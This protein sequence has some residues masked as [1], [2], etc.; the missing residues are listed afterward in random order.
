MKYA[1]LFSFLLVLTLTEF[2][3]VEKTSRENKKELRF[4]T[5]EDNLLFKLS[6]LGENFYQVKELT[7]EVVEPKKEQKQFIKKTETLKRNASINTPGNALDIQ[8]VEE[9][10][11]IRNNSQGKPNTLSRTKP[12]KTRSDF[13]KQ[14][15]N[16]QDIRET[17]EIT[18]EQEKINMISKVKR[19]FGSNAE[20]TKGGSLKLS[21]P[22]PVPELSNPRTKS[23]QGEIPEIPRIDLPELTI[24][25]KPIILKSKT[26][27]NKGLI[28]FM[29]G[30]SL[31]NR[32]EIIYVKLDAVYNNEEI[33]NFIKPESFV[34][35]IANEQLDLKV[36]IPYAE[37]KYFIFHKRDIVISTK[38]NHS[39]YRVEHSYIYDLFTLDV[40]TFGG[41]DNYTH[42]RVGVN[43]II[44]NDEI[45]IYEIDHWDVVFNKIYTF[46]AGSM[47][48]LMTAIKKER[49]LIK[50]E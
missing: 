8:K 33:K 23:L 10:I 5:N 14:K 15:N 18:K 9:A 27:P 2:K 42:I 34:D 43:E 11:P 47:I 25:E 40:Y 19:K 21:E 24:T 32:E 38:I 26:K 30:F 4:E 22:V 36:I 46:K 28:K 3:F 41:S 48:N 16:K 7:I 12:T 49:R 29:I 35:K 50:G 1:I 37:Y 45:N 6:S 13:K 17:L 31:D 39:M 20:K 44:K